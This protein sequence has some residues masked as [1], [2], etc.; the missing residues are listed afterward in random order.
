MLVQKQEAIAVFLLWAIIWGWS[1]SRLHA[2]S[3]FPTELKTWEITTVVGL[4]DS[5]MKNAVV[6][7]GGG[8]SILLSIKEKNPLNGEW[9]KIKFAYSVPYT[10]TS[11]APRL[12]GRILFLTGAA[13]NGD[14]VI[15]RWV[16]PLAA[17]GY[18][19]TLDPPPTSIE[20]PRGPFDANVVINGGG[21]ISQSSRFIKAFGAISVFAQPIPEKT[22][23]YRGSSYGLFDDIAA[24]PEGRYLLLHA[25]GTGDVCYI[26]L[27]EA[28]YPVEVLYSPAT[29][30]HLQNPAT[31][32]LFDHTVLGIRFAYLTEYNPTPVAGAVRTVLHDTDNDGVFDFAES[33][34]TTEWSSSPFADSH[35]WRDPTSL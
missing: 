32:D 28:P 5:V 25:H 11:L 7:S 2:Q 26:P 23:I 16:F 29:M 3:S 10:I 34:S 19:V 8:T 6:W 13:T 15:E 20:V 17:W 4:R 14:A 12:G 21:Y 31:V 35:Q 22:E 24:D 30:P 1:G 18:K 9:E 33:F 27:E